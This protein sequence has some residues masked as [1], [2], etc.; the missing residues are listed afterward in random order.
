MDSLYDRDVAEWAS[1]N[2]ELLRNH[3]FAEADIEN[4]AEEIEDLSLNRQHSL[5]SHFRILIAHLRKWQFQ[6]EQRSNSWR[7]TILNSRD[8]I[9]E[10]LEESPSLR[11][12][13]PEALEKGYARA[14]RFSSRET[15]LATTAFPVAC[16]Y[17]LEQILDFDYLP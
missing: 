9:D 10:L 16:P 14:V 4:I 3:R 7:R 17:S 13:L 15:D 12:R 5:F 11:V 6:P 8:A 1:R 2:A